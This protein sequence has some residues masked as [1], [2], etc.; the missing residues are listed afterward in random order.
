[1]SSFPQSLLPVS[2]A[3]WLEEAPGLGSWSHP[4]AVCQAAWS[5][6][7]CNNPALRTAPWGRHGSSDA[8]PD[9]DLLPPLKE[10]AMLGVGS[11]WTRRAENVVR[12][13]KTQGAS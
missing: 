5:G 10:A 2:A 1:M 4:G 11:P 6:L 12:P 8:A 13:R 3:F 9:I 7:R